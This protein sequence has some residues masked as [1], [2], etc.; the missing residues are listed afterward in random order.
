[1]TGPRCL[2]VPGR[3]RMISV[4]M[5]RLLTF[6]GLSLERRDGSAPPRVRPQRLAILAV[7]AAAGD[8]R[9]ARE[10]ICGLLWPDTSESRARHALRQALYALSHEVDADIIQTEPVL[11]LDQNVLTADVTEFQ[12]AV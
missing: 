2:T 9:G 4:N 7:I 5:L 6:G 12:A 3:R 8:R 10:R 11:R 1:M